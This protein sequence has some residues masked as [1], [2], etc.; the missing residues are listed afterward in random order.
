MVSV[1][2]EDSGEESKKQ[3]CLICL[4]SVSSSRF[5]Q[6]PTDCTHVVCLDCYKR[7]VHDAKGKTCPVCR[8]PFPLSEEDKKL[9]SS[10]AEAEKLS[11]AYLRDRT[12]K[13]PNCGELVCKVG[14]CDVVQCRCGSLFLWRPEWPRD[15]EPGGQSLGYG[16]EFGLNF[17]ITTF[18]FISSFAI[19][20]II[21]R[22]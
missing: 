19:V 8:A 4:E 20:S 7:W 6:F 14:G 2:E 5:T 12:R 10:R 9:F 16:V 11:Q 3:D 1:L 18:A 22:I 21:K 17:A 13:C 15:S